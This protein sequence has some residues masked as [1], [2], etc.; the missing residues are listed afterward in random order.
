MNTGGLPRCFL[1]SRNTISI[2]ESALYLSIPEDWESNTNVSF[3]L[4]MDNKFMQCLHMPPEQRRLQLWPGGILSK[5]KI[6]N[7][8]IQIKCQH[9]NEGQNEHAKQH[10]QCVLFL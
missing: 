4:A 1:I 9:R 7:S 8:F 3:G 6:A 2:P 10:S 5:T